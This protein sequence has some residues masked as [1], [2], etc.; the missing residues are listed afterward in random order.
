MV[1]SP[2]TLPVW[3]AF[4]HLEGLACRVNQ[5]T[6]VGAPGLDNGARIDEARQNLAY[7]NLCRSLDAIML[8]RFISR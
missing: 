5:L 3:Q 4:V 8:L 6:K 7:S 1:L 2:M